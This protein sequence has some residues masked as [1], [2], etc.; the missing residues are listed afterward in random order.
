MSR[1]AVFI[2]GGYFKRVLRQGFGEPQISYQK[3]S[4]LAANS[5]ER[6]RTYYYDCAPY[7]SASAD[8]GRRPFDR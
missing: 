5:E 3:L 4:E 7:Q 6:L 8:R 2:D 1:Y